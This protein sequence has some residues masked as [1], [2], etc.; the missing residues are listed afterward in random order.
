[1]L[2][3]ILWACIIAITWNSKS[4]NVIVLLSHESSKKHDSSQRTSTGVELFHIS[5]LSII[6]D[7]LF[8]YNNFATNM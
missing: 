8:H 4:G 7:T 5:I 6:V 3:D 2:G 1:M